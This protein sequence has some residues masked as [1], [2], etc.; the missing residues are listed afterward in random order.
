[1]AFL[2][3]RMTSA[4][5]RGR[6]Y[7]PLPAGGPAG[8]LATALARRVMAAITAMAA[9]TAKTAM[10]ALAATALLAAWALPAGAQPAPVA[11]PA[12]ADASPADATRVAVQS[13]RIDGNTLLDGALLQA[14]VRPWLGQRTLAELRQAAQAVQALYGQAGYGAVVAYL[15]PQAPA[16]GELLIQVIEGRVGRIS[17]MGQRRL[18]AERVRAALPTLVPGATPQVQRIDAE[19]QIANENPSRV[20][21]VLLSPGA[22]PGEVHANVQVDEQALQRVSLVLDNSGNAR[23]GDYRLGLGWQHADAT[24]HDD[25]F[26]LQLQVSPTRWQA[27]RV[28]SA[29]YRLPWVQALAALDVFAAYSDVDGGLQASAAGGLRFAGKGHVAGSRI[30]RYLPRWAELDQRL[31]GGLDYRAYLNDCQVAGLPAGACGAAGRSVALQPLTLEYA[32]Q[33]GGPWPTAF[34]LVLAH[35]LALG[36]RHGSAAD[37]AAVRSGAS[38]HYNVLRAAGQTSLPVWDDSL[39]TGRFA[40]QH[41]ADRLVPGEQFGLGG[42]GSVRGYGERALAGDTGWLASIELATAR[43]DSL[44]ALADTDARLLVFVDAGQVANHGDLPCQGQ[45]RRCGLS[46]LGI[47][48]R[49][50]WRTLHLRLFVA[51]ALQDAA[52]TRRHDWRTHFALSARF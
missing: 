14:T 19:L 47:G 9:K 32:A 48:A 5:S 41:S 15:P 24:G 13:F 8:L 2:G 25:V 20:I 49:L 1:M 30:T 46:A 42:A 23:T 51:Q 50:G 52:A 37:F 3:E 18:S 35:N 33:S 4:I 6:R 7:R 43:L 22:A 27:V 40:A 12:A 36:G 11:G 39:L 16:S 28:V 26:S 29:G 17:V 38:R 31:V 10:T 34:N 45:Q 44:L 21:G